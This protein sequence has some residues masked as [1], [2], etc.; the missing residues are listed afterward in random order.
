[1][2]LS[3]NLN[4]LR[5]SLLA[6]AVGLSLCASTAWGAEGDQPNVR[7]LLLGTKGGPSLLQT[8]SLPQSTVLMVNNDAYLLDAGYGASLRLVEAGIPLRN[9]KG[10]FITHL[11]SDHVLDY[12][13]V[14]MNGWASGLKNPVKVFGPQG[15]QEMTEHAWKTF[16]VDIDLRIADEGKP[17]PRPL[18]TT[19]TIEEG[20]VYQDQNLKVSAVAVPHPPFD[21]GQAFAFKFEVG[22]KNIVLSGDTNY[23]ADLARFAKDADVFIS[24]VVHVEGVQRLADRIG[25]GSK[26]AEAIISHHVTAED[27]GRM[28]TD[29]KVKQ[30]VLSHFVPADDPTLTAEH[31]RSAVAKT[32]AG[33]IVVGHDGMEIPLQ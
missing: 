21:K 31:W 17:D 24:E 26:L 15:I 33:E 4:A 32:Y 14:L 18:V 22:G 6:T 25:N 2:K 30:V 13:S 11:H 1:M 8:K 7:L 23:S 29:A 9:I 27:V 12:P 5:K 28:A 3:S 20:L 16:Q 19:Q 10:I